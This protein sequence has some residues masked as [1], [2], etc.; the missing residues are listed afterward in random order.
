M[1]EQE[2]LRLE[3]QVGSPNTI[4]DWKNFCRDISVEYLHAHPIQSGGPGR[5]SQS[6]VSGWAW[7]GERWPYSGRALRARGHRAGYEL[8]PGAG[9]KS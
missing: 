3:A 7:K 9:R 5:I 8:F 4:V 2:M 6:D 1:A